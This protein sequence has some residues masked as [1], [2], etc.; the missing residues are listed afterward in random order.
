MSNVATPT[1][2]APT[3]VPSLNPNGTLEAL[4]KLN[5]I[6]KVSSVAD[7]MRY[8]GKAG[9]EDVLLDTNDS[10][11][12]Y[13][14]QIDANGFVRVDRRRCIAEAEPTQQDLYDARYLSREE[15]RE[16]MDQFK[17]FR[18]EMNNNVRIISATDTA[19]SNTTSPTTKQ[20]SGSNKSVQNNKEFNKS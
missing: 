15:F 16:F 11:I 8:P 10:E 9:S 6:P 20:Y 1:V 7:A 3:L 12:A 17:E 4:V 18:E 14:R 13:F 19:N 2:T 5:E